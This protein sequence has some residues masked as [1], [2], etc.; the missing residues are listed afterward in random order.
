[1]HNRRHWILGAFGVCVVITLSFSALQLKLIRIPTDGMQPTFKEGQNVLFVRI[2][3]IHKADR[4]KVVLFESTGPAATTEPLLMV[5]RLA[6]F[7]GDTI[8]SDGTFIMVNGTPVSTVPVASY[9]PPSISFDLPLIVPEGEY[10]VVGDNHHN[11]YD[12]RHFG[13]VDESSISHRALVHREAEA[14]QAQQGVAPPSAP[15]SESNSEGNDKPQPES[16]PRPR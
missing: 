10:F 2:G 12:S 4:G 14:I 8:G 3:T 11:S 13:F 9:P 1:M 6:G 5:K 15:R 16:E 7:P